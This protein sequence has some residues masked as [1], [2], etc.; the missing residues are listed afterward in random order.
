[1]RRLWYSLAGR[2]RQVGASS[3]HCEHICG[4]MRGVKGR[5]TG[6]KLHVNV[7]VTQMSSHGLAG[8]FDWGGPRRLSILRNANVACLCRLFIP[9]LLSLRNDHVTCHYDFYTPVKS[10][11]H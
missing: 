9:I 5:I 7:M 6:Q 11:C 3:R 10:S 4:I 2:C 1:M 8:A